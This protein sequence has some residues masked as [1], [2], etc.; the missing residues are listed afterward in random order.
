MLGPKAP[1][2]LSARIRDRMSF[3]WK[4]DWEHVVVVVVVVLE[5]E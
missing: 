1:V 4:R 3:S 2:P 5:A